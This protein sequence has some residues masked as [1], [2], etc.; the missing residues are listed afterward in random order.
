MEFV[1]TPTFTRRLTRRLNDDEFRKLED[2]LCRRPD[3]GTLIPGG[4]GLRKL[5]WGIRGR[6]KRGGLRV[7]YYWFVQES[8]VYLLY[9]FAKNEA[10]DISPEQLRVLQRLVEEEAK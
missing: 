10:A 5:R 1:E 9:L 6:G 8:R 7:I 2:A 3:A 4:N